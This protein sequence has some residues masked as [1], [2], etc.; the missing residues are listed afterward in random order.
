L[1]KIADTGIGMEQ[2]HHQLVFEPFYQVEGPESGKYEGIG[3]GLSN[4][5]L[6]AKKLGGRISLE[7]T[8]GKGSVF[9]IYLPV[10]PLLS[11]A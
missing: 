6:Q 9:G 7:S 2:A 11:H 1:I 8:L 4:A 5:N 3:L 10:A